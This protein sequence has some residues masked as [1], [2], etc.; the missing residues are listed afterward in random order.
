MDIYN[1]YNRPKGKAT[2]FTG[3]TRTEQTHKKD[4]DINEIIRRSKKT[5][6]IPTYPVNWG[7]DFT[8]LPDF[9]EMQEKLAKAKEAFEMLPANT[10]LMFDNNPGKLVDFATN[11]DNRQKCEELGILPKQAPIA[12]ETPTAP[13]TPSAPEAV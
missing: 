1:K 7:G 9:H 3:P 8:N 6:F 12:P 2:T 11:P 4:C 10:R 13:I 5:G